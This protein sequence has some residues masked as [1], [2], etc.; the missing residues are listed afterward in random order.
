MPS[1]QA[2]FEVFGRIKGGAKLD[3]GEFEDSLSGDNKGVEDALRYILSV[4]SGPIASESDTVDDTGNRGCG[5]CL[6]PRA[7]L[8]RACRA[9]TLFL[10]SVEP[11]LEQ[12]GEYHGLTF[13]RGRAA[14]QSALGVQDDANWA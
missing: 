7:T 3:V 1:R 10:R 11:L 14:V 2:K 8:P 12:C 5:E 9:P 4:I 13:R 6:L